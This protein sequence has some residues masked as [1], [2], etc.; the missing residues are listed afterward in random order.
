MVPGPKADF[1]FAAISPCFAKISA[2][3][4]RQPF[5]PASFPRPKSRRSESALPVAVEEMGSLLLRPAHVLRRY[6]PRVRASPSSPHPLT[7]TNMSEWR[8]S[9]IPTGE[10]PVV[11]VGANGGSGRTALPHLKLLN[12][13]NLL[14]LQNRPGRQK[15]TA[16]P[17]PPNVKSRLNSGPGV[18]FTASRA[19]L[20]T[21]Q[22]CPTNVKSFTWSTS[23]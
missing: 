20:P 11:P 9:F 8:G 21:T 13:L 3:P 2:A 5:I 22:N 14:N 1:I 12:P 16:T 19:S 17:T 23:L 6:P 7:R 10:T 18:A 4:S 15:S